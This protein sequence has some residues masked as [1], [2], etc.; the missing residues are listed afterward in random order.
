MMNGLLTT[1][2]RLLFQ[3]YAAGDTGAAV[4][5]KR[6]IIEWNANNGGRLRWD[7]ALFLLINLDHLIMRPYFGEISGEANGVLPLPNELA[8]SDWF[9]RATDATGLILAWMA[10][11]EGE[12]S[13]H[14]V[15]QIIDENWKELDSIFLW[16]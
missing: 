1:R 16:G 9:A 15:L 5:F 2:Y 4:Q 14:D 10:K 12:I 7:A 6:R 13:A 3:S 11:S 8:A